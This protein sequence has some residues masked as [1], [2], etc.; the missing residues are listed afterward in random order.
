MTDFYKMGDGHAPNILDQGTC[1][2][3]NMRTVVLWSLICVHGFYAAAASASEAAP[4]TL[5]ELEFMT[6]CWHGEGWLRR[7]PELEK[8]KSTELVEFKAGKTVLAI[9]GKHTDSDTSALVH[10]AFA[11]VSRAA[12]GEDYRFKSFLAT[13]QSGEYSAKLSNGAFVW[14]LPIPNRGVM[15]YTIRV[16]GDEWQET[17]HYSPD[18]SQWHETFGMTLKRAKP[19]AECSR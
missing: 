12:E 8:F 9:T 7:G 19:G 6:G 15:R 17:G 13:G 2:E 11:I 10:D 14:E 4:Q 5:D 3:L 18:G 16:D 1:G